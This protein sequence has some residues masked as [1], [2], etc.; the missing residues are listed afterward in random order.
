[1]PGNSQSSVDKKLKVKQKI[2]ENDWNYQ[3]NISN[4]IFQE[5]CVNNHEQVLI[6][7]GVTVRN[8]TVS[9]SEVQR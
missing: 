4:D 5:K 8:V 6:V 1:M 7:Q 2:N 9:I 3:K